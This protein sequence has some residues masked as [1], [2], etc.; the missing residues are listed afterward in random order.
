MYRDAVEDPLDDHGMIQQQLDQLSTIGRCEYEKTCA[1]IVSLF[2]E[3]AT[4]YQELVSQGQLNNAQLT[5]QE[6]EECK[7]KVL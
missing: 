4:Q 2:D 7:K 1:L 3:S 5:V 6:G